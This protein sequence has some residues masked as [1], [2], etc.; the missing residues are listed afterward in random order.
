M[1]P[2]AGSSIHFKHRS[3]VLV[4]W[5]REIGRDDIDAAYIETD[6]PRYPFGKKNIVRM[7]DVGNIRCSS[8]RAP[9]CSFF[10]V[11]HLILAQ[12]RS[13]SKPFFF[14]YLFGD[15]V[16]LYLGENIIMPVTSPWVGILLV[17]QLADRGNSIASNSTGSS[18]GGSHQ[19]MVDPQQAVIIALHIALN[20]LS[21][22][23]LLRAPECV[24]CLL[25]GLY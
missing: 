2:E 22:G 8:S 21:F 25:L 4:Q 20:D 19:L 6:D 23:Y 3:T 9:V 24:Y 13:H 15:R 5:L 11:Q 18:F 12:H 14:E 1:H 10:K 17:D 16:H 7:N